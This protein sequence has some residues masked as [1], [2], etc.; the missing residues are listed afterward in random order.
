MRKVED[1][2]KTKV[3]SRSDVDNLVQ[4]KESSVGNTDPEYRFAKTRCVESA[5]CNLDER[6]YA[7]EADQNPQANMAGVCSEGLCQFAVLPLHGEA[8]QISDKHG[9]QDDEH[10]GPG[11]CS[12]SAESRVDR[13]R[14]SHG[15]ALRLN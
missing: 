11:L 7:D 5:H 10:A 14:V 12:D 1:W 2:V 6:V 15:Y 4:Y 3:L 9:E 13:G 8:N